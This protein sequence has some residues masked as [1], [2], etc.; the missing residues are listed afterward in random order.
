MLL[1]SSN[2][3]G[4]TTLEW[5]SGPRFVKLSRSDAAIT[6]VDHDLRGCAVL[7]IEGDQIGVINDLL[8]DLEDQRVCFLDVES[9]GFLGMGEHRS[10]IPIEAMSG[11]DAQCVFVDH[12]SDHVF[13]APIHNPHVVETM[14]YLN[15]V[16]EYYG[17]APP[18]AADLEGS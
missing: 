3:Q 8:I 15:D 17:Y 14:P 18:W 6:Y 10:L 5:R 4:D 7:T 9:N 2:W 11:F 1:A 12:S 13:A 16:Y